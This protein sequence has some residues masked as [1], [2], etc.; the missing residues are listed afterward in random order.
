MLV[1]KAVEPL[2]LWGG[3]EC[4]VNRVGDR[5]FDQLRQSGHDR[6][7]DDIDA[8]AELG[9]TALR[10]PVLWER[11]APKDPHQS[12]WSWSD[13]RLERLGA[14]GIEPIV[15]LVHHGSGPHY[16]NLLDPG[17]AAGLA[18]HASA[19][20]RRY[21]W[22]ELY[23]PINEP[24]TTARFSGLYGWWYPHRRDDGAF[25]RIL[26]NQ[27][28]AVQLAMRAIRR[29][30]PR[31]RLLQ[32]EDLGLTLCTPGL[33]EQAKF[34]NQRRFASFD[35]LCGRVDRD[36]PLYGYLRRHG[37]S[38]DELAALRDEPPPDLLGA[39]HYVTSTRLLDERI[40]HYR[41]DRIGG[42]GRRAYVDMEA[43]RVCAGG[44]VEPARLL[45]QLWDN[46]RIPIVITEVQ[47][48]GPVDEQ[49][50]WFKEL[51]DAAQHCRERGID[52]RAITS[53]SLL[54]AFDWHCLVTRAHDRYEPGA[55]DVSDGIPRLTA[56][57]EYLREVANGRP[58]QHAALAQPGW[59]RRFDR[60]LHPPVRSIDTSADSF[61]APLRSVARQPK[62]GSGE[63][64]CGCS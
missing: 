55:F 50:R 46:Y 14:R 15:G 39:N 19:V 23:T 6:R 48:A 28:R 60:L 30:N 36:W 38:E 59:W 43:V 34:E 7:L 1:P 21:P 49:I 63:V 32:T 24:L 64:Q 5:S 57:G 61:A 25:C 16:T 47:L 4:T 27:C 8:I 51:W 2:A 58:D 13:A 3:I 37:I 54:G 17:F 53:W 18:R 35:L 11:T 29:V 42:N 52:L 44:F 56:L 45:G 40:E 62:V 41:P 12:D 10:Y 33:T 26:I 20:A 22:V 9:V 31:A